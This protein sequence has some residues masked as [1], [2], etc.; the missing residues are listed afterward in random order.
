VHGIFPLGFIP[1]TKTRRYIMQQKLQTPWYNKTITTLQLAGKG[2]RTQETYAR[3]VR[4]LFEYCNC[5]TV[6]K[7][8]RNREN[9]D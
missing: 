3:S 1:I 4:Q 5:G 9:K 7:P 8:D 6:G 2:D